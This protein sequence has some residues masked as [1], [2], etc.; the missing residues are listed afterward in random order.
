VKILAIRGSNLASLAGE[1]EI[2]LAHGPLG[3][4]GVFDRLLA[5]IRGDVH[6]LAEAS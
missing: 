1:L 4:A 5:E 6:D 3:G 2:D